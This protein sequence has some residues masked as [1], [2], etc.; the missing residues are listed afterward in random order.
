MRITVDRDKCCGSGMCVMR[1]EAV[2][3]QD[4][5]DGLARL[6]VKDPDPRHYESVKSA[7]SLCPTQAITVIYDNKSHND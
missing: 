2:F 1:A 4:E 3:R 5:E 6:V 7:A